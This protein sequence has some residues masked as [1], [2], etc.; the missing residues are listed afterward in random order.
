MKIGDVGMIY[1]FRHPNVIILYKW[2]GGTISH[3][4]MLT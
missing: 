1:T 4:K 3:T 2:C